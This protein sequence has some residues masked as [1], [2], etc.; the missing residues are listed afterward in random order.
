MKNVIK[1]TLILT[2]LLFCLNQSAFAGDELTEEQL[3]LKADVEHSLIAPCC[4]N[5]TV[6]QHESPMAKQV[7][8][9]VTKL[10]LEG[11]D[12]P[13]ILAYFS[14]QPKYGE[15]IL[16]T[17]AQDNLLGKLAYWLIPLA[18]VVGAIAIYAT[19][20][21][22]SRKPKSNAPV[23]EEQPDQSPTAVDSTKTSGK[24]DDWQQKVENE[25]KDFE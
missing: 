6:D 2:G 4:W 18:F 1:Y 19:V 14:S 15:R 21:R 23:V 3:A 17:P 10:I 22:L 5:M 13:Q 25:L 24:D 16:A 8:D 7:R 9:Q 20:K 11:K 12:K